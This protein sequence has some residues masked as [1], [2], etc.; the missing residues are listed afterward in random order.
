MLLELVASLPDPKS[1]ESVGWL[2]LTI[3]STA[4]AGNQTMGLLEKFRQFRKPA[5]GDVTEDRIKAIEKRLDKSDGA[6]RQ[7]EIRQES[8]MAEMRAMMKSTT[9]TLTNLQNDWSYSIGRI[10]G[11]EE[12]KG[13]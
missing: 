7:S 12:N 1:A 10:D 6:I 3:A 5:A 9:D 8:H 4:V 13:N 11:R 2:L